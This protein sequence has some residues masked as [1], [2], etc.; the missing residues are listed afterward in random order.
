MAF[1][2]AAD[3]NLKTVEHINTADGCIKYANFAVVKLTRLKI[4]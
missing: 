4:K 2:E 3:D 1:A